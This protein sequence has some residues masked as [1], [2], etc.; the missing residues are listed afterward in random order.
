MLS[1]AVFDESGPAKSWPARLAHLQGAGDL[2]LQGTVTFSNGR[3]LCEKTTPET[4]QLVVQVHVD[5]PSLANSKPPLLTDTGLGV[6]SLKT[7]LLPDRDQPYLLN[8]E[9]ARHQIM[10]F[11]NKL[12]DWNLVDLPLDNPVLQEFELARRS[13]TAALVA[14]RH[15]DDTLASNPTTNPAS[16]TPPTAKPH[17]HWDFSPQADRMAR[18]SLAQALDAGEKLAVLAAERQM[19]QRLSG[20]VY[21]KAVAT[22][23]SLTGE[24]PAPGVPLAVPGAGTCVVATPPV[25]GCAISPDVFSEPIQR[26]AAAIS[27]FVVMPLRWIDMEPSEGKYNFTTTDRWIEWAVRVAKVPVAAGPLVDLRP[28]CVPEWLYIWEND[29]ETLRELVHDHIQQIVTRYRRTVTRWTVCSGLHVNSNFKLSFEQIMDLT[30]ICVLVVK[31]LHP[32]AKLQV[33]IAQP[34][35]EYHAEVKRSIP[36][37]M[38]AEAIVQSGLAVDSLGLRIQMGQPASGQSTRDLMSLSALIDRYAQLE[39]PLAISALG[40][41]SIMP[42][43]IEGRDGGVWRSPWSE[44]AQADWLARA[45][46]ICLAKPSVQSV[47][48][49]ELADGSTRA[50]MTGGGLVT[51]AGVAKLAAP[52][53]ALVRKSLREN[54]PLGAAATDLG[55]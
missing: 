48:W 13:F 55:A 35:G 21:N 36:P 27:D 45:A 37:L 30:R 2:P 40:V 26:T 46:T 1:F 11:L 10:E 25:V 31:K 14:Q 24:K 47:C 34:W 4:A 49:Q 54:K 38:Y 42:Q 19:P 44:T 15:E 12:E 50:E 52:R 3:L 28:H 41:P 20:E 32:A 51:A 43:A 23:T 33:E 17:G 6:L 22:M 7:C 18:A 16:N 53:L 8:L 9:L 39:K 29:Y 5:R